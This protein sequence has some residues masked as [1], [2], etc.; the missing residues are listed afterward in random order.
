MSAGEAESY[1]IEAVQRGDPGAWRDLI[2]RYQG[3]MISFA[4][5]MLAERSEAE[6]IVQEAFLGLLRSLPTYD[7][8]RSV[9]TYLFA[10][11][12]NKLHDYLRQRHKG[13][14]QSLEQLELDEGAQAWVDAD[15][16]SRYVADQERLAAQRAALTGTLRQ[17]VEQCTGQRR[18]QDLIVI[19]MLVVLGMRNKEVAADL[20]LAETAVAGIKFRVLDQWRT[21]TRAAAGSHEWHEADLARDS[22]V[23]RIWRE[24]GISCLKRTTLGRYLLGTLDEE[25]DAYIDF[26]V[27]HADCDRCSANLADLRSEDERD[28]AARQRLAEK[29]FASSVGFLSK[30]DA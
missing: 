23:G 5:R 21:L 11:L 7:K 14:R 30:R 28:A 12:R 22:T 16:P 9:E 10:I 19:E 15:T 29:C 27:E 13:Q 26:H 6:D 20:G 4:R 1:L 18:F 24:E 25:W 2:D 8:N 3:R 17:W